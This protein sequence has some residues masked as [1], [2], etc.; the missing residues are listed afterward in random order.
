MEKL[1]EESRDKI[2]FL[3]HSTL[4]LIIIRTH[5]T[6]HHHTMCC[7]EIGG[8]KSGRFLETKRRTLCDI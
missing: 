4:S 8:H 6:V 2:D 3:Q 5:E 1:S 7:G